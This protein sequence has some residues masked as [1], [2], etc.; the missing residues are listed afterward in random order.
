MPWRVTIPGLAFAPVIVFIPR[1]GADW[2]PGQADS[3]W[4]PRQCPACRQ[5]AVIGHGRRRRPAHDGVH[6]WILVRRGLCKVC[7]GTLT[8]LPAWCVPGAPYS[9]LA[10]QQ[11]IEQLAQGCPAEQAAPHCRD[12]AE[13]RQAYGNGRR[14]LESAGT[15]R[16]HAISPSSRG[17]QPGCARCGH[18]RWRG[19]ARYGAIAHPP[20]SAVVEPE[21]SRR[22]R[23]R[24]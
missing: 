20:N 7:G 4:L 3:E 19:F 8:V 14:C 18:S 11:A 23:A 9:L 6:D 17:T 16:R 12:G 5:M 15:A 10:R 13:E 2:K 21:S 1:S 22:V 24:R